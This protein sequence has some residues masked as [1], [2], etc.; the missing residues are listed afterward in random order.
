MMV[1][2]DKLDVPVCS[3]YTI[4]MQKIEK[5]FTKCGFRHE[6]VKRK[7]N[8]ALF[9][10]TQIGQTH[11]HFEVVRLS[12]HGGYEINGSYV[13]S[14]E[15]YPGPSL[16]GVRGWTYHDVES[17]TSKYNSLLKKWTGKKAIA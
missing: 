2:T 14:A 1:V 11:T 5:I 12:S 13:K 16:W 15:V 8:I 17:A 10:R 4:S 9:K 6:Q 7:E 3:L